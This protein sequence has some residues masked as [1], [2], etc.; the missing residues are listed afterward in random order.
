ML[1]LTALRAALLNYPTSSSCLSLLTERERSLRAAAALFS[2]RSLPLCTIQPYSL[3]FPNLQ[4]GLLHL[5]LGE[6]W[7]SAE[8]LEELLL[9]AT[10][11]Y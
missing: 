10:S 3:A 6:P 11:C 4:G 5:A 9:T 1:L 7:S 2:P 8:R